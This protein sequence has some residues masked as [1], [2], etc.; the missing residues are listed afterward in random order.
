MNSLYVTF[1]NPNTK[2]SLSRIISIRLEILSTIMEKK[3]TFLACD[4][5]RRSKLRCIADN[6]LENKCQRC[7]K[8]EIDCQYTPKRSQL[9]QKLKID[10]NDDFLNNTI[11]NLNRKYRKKPSLLDTIILPNK[12]ILIELINNFFANEYHFFNF[13]HKKSFINWIQSDFFEIEFFDYENY[14]S[15]LLLSILSIV[16]DEKLSKIYSKFDINN[17]PKKFIPTFIDFKESKSN[18]INS[19]NYFAYY[20]RLLINEVFDVPSIQ[21]IQT[22]ILLSSH[23]LSQCNYSKSHLYINISSAMCL[24]LGLFKSKDYD[25]NE[26]FY[27]NEIK[28]RTLW[29]VF[30]MDKLICSN[31]KSTID[32]EDIEIA[33]PCPD[34]NFE[35]EIDIL[36]PNYN[37]VFNYFNNLTVFDFYILFLE[38]YSKLIKLISQ[39]EDLQ[40]VFSD[41]KV[42]K[43]KI[44]SNGENS[45]YLYQLIYF[46]ELIILRNF[47]FYNSNSTD[48]RYSSYINMLKNS[49]KN[50]TNLIN[51]LV[52]KK[53]LML[54]NLTFFQIMNNFLTSLSISKLFNDEEFLK[55]SLTNFNNLAKFNHNQLND[56]YLK[57]CL[58]FNEYMNDNSYY[59]YMVKKTEITEKR[60][61]HEV[62]TNKSTARIHSY[63]NK[64][65]TTNFKDWEK[66][67]PAWN[68]IFINTTK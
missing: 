29:T 2:N 35:N 17:E 47:M 62:L 14:S 19:S 22:L 39:S 58:N 16:K 34:E 56:L 66:I 55:I 54:T 23:E 25:S 3:R 28:R 30:I 20:S 64:L 37:E 7:L 52:I 38:I 36:M 43:E 21:T 5:C 15:S 42:L 32:I 61:L 9:K 60:S 68:D 11:H 27:I 1:V 24:N 6:D 67:I 4:A 63:N 26:N 12:K 57:I 33:L 44:F 51:D 13:I 65:D 10:E 59:K 49:I 50:S 18:P 46:C 31:K 48:E 53:N 41:L 40:E 8:M 45:S